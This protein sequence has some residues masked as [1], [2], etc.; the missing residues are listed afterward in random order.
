MMRMEKRKREIIALG[1]LVVLGIAVAGAMAWYM[2]VGHSWNKAASHI[3]DLVGSMDGY[4][5]IV[6][7]GTLKHSK[8]SKSSSAPASSSKSATSASSALPDVSESA[9]K[10]SSSSSKAAS[11]SSNSKRVAVEAD[12]VDLKKV[13]SSY[14]EKGASVIR[15]HVGE[16]DRYKDPL[17]FTA[18]GRCFGIC[19]AP[20]KYRY[21]TVR[22]KV[23]KLKDAN[24]D[25]TV[26][27]TNKA[28]IMKGWLRN[29]NLVILS[30]D[31]HIP[32]GGTRIGNAFFVDA[33]EKGE[34]QAVIISPSG[35][36]TAKTITDL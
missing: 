33:A 22:D 21:V 16:L 30:C 36:V 11:A 23:L 24:A 34:V 1:L 12:A 19:A 5:V 2:M 3:D 7:E 26:V 28:G 27:L 25:F 20:G 17:V 4:T 13:I 32:S 8:A 31:A 6:Y 9:V 10:A 14:R 35:T 18:A 29:V 15:L